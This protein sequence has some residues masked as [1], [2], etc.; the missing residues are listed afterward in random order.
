LATSSHIIMKHV[1][2]AY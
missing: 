2:T 1:D